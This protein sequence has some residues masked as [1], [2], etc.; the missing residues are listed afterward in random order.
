MTTS[1]VM[2]P[3]EGLE[4]AHPDE[5]VLTLLQRMDEADVH[6]MPVVDNGRLLGMVTREHLLHHIR[7]RSELGV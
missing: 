3:V 6:Q 1:Q 4:W 5:D 7:L 2:T